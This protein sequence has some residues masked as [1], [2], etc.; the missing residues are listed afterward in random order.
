METSQSID[1]LRAISDQLPYWTFAFA[2]ASGFYF[3]MGWFSSRHISQEA[4]ESISLWLWGDYK[5]I[6]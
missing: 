4:K 3:V 1:T 2:S 6:Y 5:T